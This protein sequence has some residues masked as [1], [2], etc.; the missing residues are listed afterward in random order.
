MN[1]DERMELE[2]KKKKKKQTVFLILAILCL[3]CIGLFG[4]SL[5][6]KGNKKEFE[7][8]AYETLKSVN[9]N[10]RNDKLFN[11]EASDKT[12]IFPDKAIM[13]FNRTFFKGGSITRY[14]NGEVELV[15]Y[16]NKWCALKTRTDA[17]ITVEKYNAKSCK[18]EK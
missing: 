17:R 2:K 7:Q 14:A 6:E 13:N 5:Q 11:S 15:L 1:Y 4:S 3:C 8:N 16:N 18:I 12:Y 10:Y 9:D